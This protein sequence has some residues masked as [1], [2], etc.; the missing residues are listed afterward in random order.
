MQAGRQSSATLQ[1]ELVGRSDIYMLNYTS[2]TTGDSKGVKVSHWGILSSALVFM[3]T[4]GFTENDVVIDYL[5]APHVFDQFMFV[6]IMLSGGCQGYYQGNPLKLMEDC[7]VLQPTLFPSVPRLYNKIYAKIKSGFDAVTGCKK[8]LVTRGLAS[9]SYYLNDMPTA[10][11][12]SGCYDSL[13]FGKIAKLLGGRV[14][15]MVT[16]SAP[17][18]KDV[19]ELLKVA[20]CCPVLEAYGLSE[21]SGAV[22]AT[23]ADDPISGTIGGP[24]KHCA[25]RLKD[26]PEM[27]YRITDQPFL[28][29]EICVRSPCVTS[30]YFMRPDKTAEAIDAQG[31]LLT[32][33]VGVVYPNG[34]IRI[35][36][37]SKNIFKL[38]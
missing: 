15:M 27:D 18:S 14:R 29:G 31:Y 24:F 38:S 1:P 19:L 9:K 8:W 26:L 22:T 37:R 4:Y 20:F 28:R 35:L 36:D 33:D 16:A 32:G 7:S 30:G 17:I 34:T 6:A 21:T 10:S 13:I 3:E 2:G 12:T 25:I 11:Y 23:V 5:P